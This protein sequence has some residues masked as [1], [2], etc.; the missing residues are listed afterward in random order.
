[1]L[2]TLRRQETML[3]ARFKLSAVLAFGVVQLCALNVR[4]QSNPRDVADAPQ[5]YFGPFDAGPSRFNLSPGNAI[6]K[7]AAAP[8]KTSPLIV[9]GFMGGRVRPNNFV[10]QEASLAAGLQRDYP[11]EV[12]AQVF[13]NRDGKKAYLQILN[14][15][16]ADHDGD[17][18][19]AEKQ[20]ARI[21]IYGHSWGASETVSL[22]RRLG[23]NG[24]T[25]LLTVQ[26][27]SI[28]KKGEEDK[29]IPANVLQAVN[30]YQPSGLLHGRKVIRAVN[31]EK[32]QIVGNFRLSYR[33][34]AISCSRYPWFA[35]TF[36]RPHIEI[37]N[38]P[39]VW[40]KVEAMIRENL[41]DAGQ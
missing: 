9:V 38:D 5:K 17:L 2:C 40:D 29:Y 18:T 15:L 6:P 25:V 20:N 22:A 11:G 30:F 28:R 39:Q 13:A 1:M 12:H 26:V 24:I 32:T 10:H 19:P 4:S 34:H 33:D 7:T 3:T 36:M 35:R 14:L 21:I 16:D 31:P 8:L 37:E 27:D 41:P 23:R